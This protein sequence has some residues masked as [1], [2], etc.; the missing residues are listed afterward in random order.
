MKL[1]LLSVLFFY[2]SNDKPR[3][4]LVEVRYFLKWLR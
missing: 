1:M 3:L 4:R 2:F